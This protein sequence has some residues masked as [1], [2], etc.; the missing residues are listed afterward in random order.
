[1]PASKPWEAKWLP[2]SSRFSGG[3][4]SSFVA[5]AIDGSGR[6]AF[7]KTLTR[8]RDDRARRRF[9]REAAT[10]ETLAGLGPPRLLDHNAET[11]ADVGQPMFMALEFIDGPDLRRSVQNSGP[12]DVPSVMRCIQELAE[13]IHQ[14]HQYNVLHR[15]IKPS[16]IVLRGGNLAAPVLV[17]FGL[18]FNDEEEDDLTRVG[19]EIGNRFL[20]LPEHTLGNRTT[21]SDVTQLAGIFVYL[22][23]AMEP[24]VLVDDAGRKPHKREPLHAAL[25]ER[26][27]G[28]R[29]L[30]LESVLDRAFSSDALARYQFAPDLLNALEAA[31]ADVD[32]ADDDLESLLT[33][34]DEIAL[35]E[36]RVAIARRREGLDRILQLVHGVVRSFAQERHFNLSYSGGAAQ[37]TQDGGSIERR[38]ALSMDGQQGTFVR[39][40]VEARDPDEFVLLADG[41][42]VWRGTKDPHGSSLRDAVILVAAGRFVAD[43]ADM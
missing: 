9:R 20:R 2:G 33:R 4:S 1:V 5:T 25:A 21:A 23:T 35:G 39:Y 28:R 11:W 31:L 40:R 38:I 8:V 24:R 42:E 18:S 22:L 37:L 27:Q 15:D 7:I 6:Q 36:E 29:L 14:C 3:Q 12:R 32:N 19:E 16:N 10:Y 26:F 30:R 41:T 34:V 13:I 43:S 17:D